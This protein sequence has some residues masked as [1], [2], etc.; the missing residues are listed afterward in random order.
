MAQS[1]K[2][3]TL[4]FGSGHDLKVVRSS[5]MSGST[6]SMA[7]AAGDSLSPSFSAPPPLAFPLPLSL[8]K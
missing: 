1:D 2:H 3:P 6:L 8:S 5:P 4:D 7:G